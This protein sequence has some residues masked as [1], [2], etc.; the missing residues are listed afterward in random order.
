MIPIYSIGLVF[1]KRQT[2]FN[3][4]QQENM[5]F[6]LLFLVPLKEV[7]NT[8]ENQQVDK[9]QWYILSERLNDKVYV[10]QVKRETNGSKDQG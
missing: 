3:L 5:W 10:E 4:N 1:S 8:V 9:K 6:L 7:W 2:Q